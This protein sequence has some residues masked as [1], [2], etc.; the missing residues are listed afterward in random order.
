MRITRNHILI[1]AA[2]VGMVVLYFF[3]RLFHILSIPIF[4]DEAIYIRWA[5]IAKQDANWRFISLTD[6]K[7]PLFIW[8]AIIFLK[9]FK[10]PLLAVRLVS[11]CAGFATS[12]GLFFLGNE[13]FK[14]KEKGGSYKIFKFTQKSISVGLLTSFLYVIYP[15]GLVYDRMALYDSMV[16]A[17]AVWSLYL[18][19]LMVRSLR[20][21]VAL[22]TGLTIGAGMLT[23][24]NAFFSLYSMPFL[25]II[26]D[27]KQK[28]LKNKFLKFLG[29]CIVAAVLSNAIYSILR[30]SPFYHIIDEKNALFVYPFAEWIQHPLTYLQSNLQRLIEWFAIYVTIPG[31]ALMFSAFILKRNLFREKI[32]L[33]VWF[34]FPFIPFAFFGNT[35]YPRHILFMTLPLLPLIAY[36]LF[37]LFNNYKSVFVKIMP[38]A[39][40][41][42]WFIFMDYFI[43]ADFAH[44]PIPREDTG[45]YL[46]SWSAGNGVK[47][48]VEFFRTQAASQKIYIMTEGTF[49]LMPFGLEM[50]LVDNPNVKIDAIWPIKDMPPVQV[51]AAAKK[52][53]TYA[54]F[55]QE[56]PACKNGGEE[57]P[58]AWNVKLIAEYKQGTSNWYYRIY[59]FL[60]K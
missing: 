10:D 56:C 17:F 42:I 20:L 15:F 33:L 8:V 22:I 1:L 16:G 47:Q 54:I 7:Q 4:T 24:T 36:S 46:N 35:I 57:P 37:E 41:F 23:K 44:A 2:V 40:L 29:L 18:L 50:Y 28:T 9:F 51:V 27:W 59:Q 60:N 49:G 58:L 3:L 55:Y 11:A 21:D 6:G 25:L 14:E 13:V 31:V 12:I 52:M 30:L 43:V 53:P 26:F 39:I 32:L 45:Q 19:L 48:S 5:Q 38:A 34:L